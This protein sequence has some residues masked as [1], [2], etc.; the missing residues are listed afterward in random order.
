[1]GLLLALAFILSYLDS[2][3]PMPAVPG[4]KLGLANLAVIVCLWQ[5]GT[6]EA[7]AVSLVRILLTG[8]TFGSASAM[9]YSFTGAVLSL[10]LMCALKHSKRFST[11]GISVAGGVT[12]NLGQLL[13][14]A[15]VTK[16]GGVLYYFPVLFAAGT[17][18]GAVIGFIAGE[19]VLRLSGISK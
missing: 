12:H 15:A 18:S 2:C 5:V 19:I 6:A 16:T 13:M 3:I 11:V 17:V 10:S 1:M 14:A 4:V 8:M 7:W 9:L